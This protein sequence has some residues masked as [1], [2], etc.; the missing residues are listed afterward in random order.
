MRR[1]RH[2]F[3]TTL[4]ARLL[5]LQLAIVVVT[6]AVVAVAGF[7][8]VRQ[9]LYDQ[10]GQRSLAVARTVANLPDT[11]RALETGDPEHELQ[12]IVE[13]I[14]VE[15]GM[16]YIA[17][18]DENGIRLTHPNPDRIGERL[19]TDPSAVLDG[20]TTI[21]TETGTL[22]ETTRAKV[23][24]FDDDGTIIGLVSVGVSTT[25]INHH[26]LIKQRWVI[27][28]VCAALG[29]GVIASVILARRVRRET[30]GLAP[31]EIATLYEQR[32]AMLLSIREGVVTL[33]ADGVVTLINAEARR[34]LG[35]DDA[36]EGTRLRDRVTS[37]HFAAVIDGHHDGQDTTVVSD[38]R[39]LVVSW[40]PVWVRNREIGAVITLRDRTELEGLVRELA[41]VQGMADSLRAKAH[42]Y[43]NRMHTIAGLLELGHA[44]EA[45]RYAASESQIAQ[46][47][48]EAFAEQLG[49]PTLVALLLSK[50]AVAAERGI[51]LRIVRDDALTSAQLTATHDIVTVAGNLIDNALDAAAA[52]DLSPRWV[53]V[54]LRADASALIVTVSDSGV[55]VPAGDA[56]QIFEYGYTTKEP[57]AGAPSRGIGLA[58]VAETVSR[59]G[60]SVELVARPGAGATFR[61][62]LR[63]VLE[64]EPTLVPQ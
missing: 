7:F 27:A 17:V 54:D 50:S 5:A 51:E 63:G 15:T 24:I 19:S 1:R 12:A 21:S 32:E 61:A 55:G 8:N 34:L 26:T 29:L 28:A 16:T 53:E 49:D 59:H 48:T 57:L 10:F 46:S 22:G 41:S 33:D 36:V 44:D 11:R 30:F 9:T 52:G 35:I 18:A 60:G 40:R 42:E 23:P 2:L 25:E 62:V 14:R 20:E 6:L 58:L 38:G 64:A 45:A 3:P 56:G 43:S 39:V 4:S 13:R 47:L 37:P 31:A